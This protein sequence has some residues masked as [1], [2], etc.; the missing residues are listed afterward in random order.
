M[1]N[2]CLEDNYGKNDERQMLKIYFEFILVE[3]MLV[4]VMVV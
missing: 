3:V 1:Q 4:V 2:R